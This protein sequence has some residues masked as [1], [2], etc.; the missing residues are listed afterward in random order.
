MA[1]CDVAV[2]SSACQGSLDRINC[3]RR[4][5]CF[6]GRVVALIAVASLAAVYARKPLGDTPSIPSALA[7]VL[8]LSS[9]SMPR[10]GATASGTLVGAAAV[11]SLPVCSWR[12][13]L[14]AIKLATGD[15]V[16]SPSSCGPGGGGVDTV[17]LEL[18]LGD[19]ETKNSFD[20]GGVV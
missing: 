3:L 11:M 5:F 4:C 15:G 9:V 20:H 13:C 17:L 19:L 16:S 14:P 2:A 6:F 18:K 10:E 12:P 8:A 1:E 7:A